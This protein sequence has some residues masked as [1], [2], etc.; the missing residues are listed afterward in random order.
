MARIRR[1]TPVKTSLT[2][3]AV[4]L[5]LRT[6]ACRPFGLDTAPTSSLAPRLPRQGHWV[7]REEVPEKARIAC[8]ARAR[9]GRRSDLS[10]PNIGTQYSHKLSQTLT[11][12]LGITFIQIP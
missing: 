3:R 1:A 7:F 4:T 6:L 11:T 9:S 5:P 8:H 10:A 12:I 2:F